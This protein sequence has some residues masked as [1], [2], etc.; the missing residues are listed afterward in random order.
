M[1]HCDKCK[2]NYSDDNRY[3]PKC[4]SELSY[5]PELVD[6]HRILDILKALPGY[7]KILQS[8][9]IQH[10]DDLVYFDYIMVHEAGIFAF[11]INEIYRIVEG[12]DRM[13]FWTAEDNRNRGAVIRIERPVSLLE[14]N[15]SVLDRALRRYTFTKSFAFLIFPDDGGLERVTSVHLDQMLTVPRMSAILIRT[16]DNYGHVYDRST[17]DKVYGILSNLAGGHENNQNTKVPKAQRRART[18]RIFSVFV[19]LSACFLSLL[20][21]LNKDDLSLKHSRLF[22]PE[23]LI[24]Q[25]N[26]Q[27]TADISTYIIPSVCS[28]LFS[29]FDQN[30]MDQAAKALGIRSFECQHDG[31]ISC[32]LNEQEKSSI[33]AA[34]DF[35][36]HNKLDSLF[37]QKALPHF[38]SVRTNDHAQFTIFVTSQEQNTTESEIVAELLRFGVLCAILETQPLDS[39][40]VSFL[41]QAGQGLSK[42]SLSDYIR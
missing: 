2:I 14:K 23:K 29:P 6:R 27:S 20:F 40:S 37:S 34:A 18:I 17:V 24:V 41:N 38:T 31:S 16:I 11:Q 25:N 22:S 1:R 32:A 3:C 19:I 28:P 15:H 30:A 8:C 35:A 39:V 5:R 9:T 7:K 4:G 33:L 12:N 21:L 26:S 10:Y 13:R 36:F 42:T